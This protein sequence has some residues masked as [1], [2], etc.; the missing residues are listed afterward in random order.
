MIRI[1]FGYY[2]ILSYLVNFEY[3]TEI[4]YSMVFIEIL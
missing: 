2:H 1:V 3:L 4:Q